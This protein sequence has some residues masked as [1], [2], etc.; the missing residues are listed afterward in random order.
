MFTP[1]KDVVFIH[2]DDVV[3]WHGYRDHFVTMCVYVCM[4]A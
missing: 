4:L 1:A 2:A 3:Q